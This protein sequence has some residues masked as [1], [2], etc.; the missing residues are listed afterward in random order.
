MIAIVALPA[1][2]AMLYVPAALISIIRFSVASLTASSNASMAKSMLA[3]PAGIVSDAGNAA[4]R[5]AFVASASPLRKLN[6]TS[7]ADVLDPVRLIRRLAASPN[8]P[9]EA[10]VAIIDITG[11]V[12]VGVVVGVVMLTSSIA[13]P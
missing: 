6:C 8:S 7:N 10:S 4:L 13:K 3:A 5:S 11:S 1:V 12:G 2:S 9:A